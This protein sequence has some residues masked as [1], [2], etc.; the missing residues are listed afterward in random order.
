MPWNWMPGTFAVPNKCDGRRTFAVIT[1]RL[2]KPD[3]VAA[4]I[5]FVNEQT[6]DVLTRLH[7]F[8]DQQ[9]VP[10][11]TPLAII[12]DGG[13]DVSYPS[14]LPWRPVRRILDWFHIAMRFEHVLQRIRAMRHAQPDESS[15]LMKYAESA[16]WRLWHGRADGCIERLRLVREEAPDLL[17]VRVKEL[18]EYLT[19]N[20]DRLIHY[21]ARYRAGLP[22]S[23]S[24]A[25]SAVNWVIGDRF[26]KKGQMRWTP[27]GANA[28]LHIRVADLNGELADHIRSVY[29]MRQSANHE[30]FETAA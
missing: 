5:G 7:H 9:A 23:T 11:D 21:A 26:K 29:Q 10:D 15:R 8:L 1:G 18:I 27:I 24:L 28:L 20:R 4:S 6:R 3:A 14:Y 16:K 22:V 25:E 12:C 2:R 19:A 13:E 30:H 17:A